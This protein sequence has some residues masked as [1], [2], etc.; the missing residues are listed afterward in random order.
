MNRLPSSPP[1]IADLTASFL[2]RTE[3]AE[4]LSAAADALGDVE[5]HEVSVGYRAEPRLAW[6][7]SLEVLAPFG[8]KADPIPAPAEWGS[9]VARQEG[10]AALPFALGNYPQRARNL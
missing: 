4:T 7:E 10:L 8:L 1:S 2:R 5:P 3:D 9:L 6:H